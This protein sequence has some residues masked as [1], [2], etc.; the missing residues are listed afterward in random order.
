MCPTLN[1]HIFCVKKPTHFC[2]TAVKVI[3]AISDDTCQS[4]LDG[5]LRGVDGV[6]DGGVLV[7]GVVVPGHQAPHNLVLI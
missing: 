1:P 6:V 7:A 4:E 3:K 2:E 5:V